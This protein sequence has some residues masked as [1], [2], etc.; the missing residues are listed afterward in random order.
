MS[1]AAL[2]DQDENAE[3]DN[4]LLK[5]VSQ[6][7]HDYLEHYRKI[8]RDDRFFKYI[9][10]NIIKLAIEEFK[11]EGEYKPLDDP[12]IQGIRRDI[13]T[14]IIEGR[15]DVRQLTQLMGEAFKQTQ[16]AA[17]SNKKDANQQ[18]YISH[19]IKK[20]QDK[21]QRIFDLEVLFLELD[22]SFKP[23]EK[24]LLTKIIAGEELA[25]HQIKE[26]LRVEKQRIIDRVAEIYKYHEGE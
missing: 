20:I 22:V 8:S 21:A 12:K 15:A 3:V 17:K 13:K 18:V 1:Q 9:S 10:D 14:C 7:E 4:P 16:T 24:E 25:K 11:E 26:A 23:I 2:F 6:L 5:N 19:I